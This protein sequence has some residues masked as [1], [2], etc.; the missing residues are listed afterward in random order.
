MD[1]TSET[2]RLLHKSAGIGAVITGV[3]VIAMGLKW[4]CRPIMIIVAAVTLALTI[5]A[6]SAGLSLRT[7]A[8]YDLAMWAMRLLGLAA[9][10]AACINLGLAY[11]LKR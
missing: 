9:L 5:A 7:A 8:S 4:R 2:V 1:I 11:R 3:A 6:A 10:T